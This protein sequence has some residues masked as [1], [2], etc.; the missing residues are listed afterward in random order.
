MK[1]NL[2]GSAKTIITSTQGLDISVCSAGI[3]WDRGSSVDGS[4]SAKPLTGDT[5]RLLGLALYT[6]GDGT[7]S[8]LLPSPVLFFSKL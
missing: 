6:S 7:G 8:K 3:G 1:I 2:R 4:M 5:P